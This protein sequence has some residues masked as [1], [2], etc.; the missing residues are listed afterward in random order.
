MRHGRV[1][2]RR[3]R[4]RAHRDA[5]RGRATD[6]CPDPG[7]TAAAR[8]TFTQAGRTRLG[9]C[10][11]RTIR[12]MPGTAPVVVDSAGCGAAMK[13]YG[14]LLGTRRGPGVLRSGSSTSRSG[15]PG[16]PQSRCAPRDQSVVVQDACHLRHVQKAHLAVRSVLRGALRRDRDRRRR[17]VL[18]RGGC[19][20]RAATRSV[21]CRPHA[22]G[23]CHRGRW[24]Y[25]SPSGLGQPR[26]HDA[27]A[28]GG[29][30]QCVTPP[31]SWRLH[32]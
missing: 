4:R 27:P 29:S 2:T 25:A 15:S 11:E 21:D 18:R 5:R 24:R 10:A 13:D 20:Q 16:S 32:W 17:V 31:S 3:P 1:G 23:R 19:V 22:Q 14:R 26:L 28:G 6:G 8:C 7:P 9:V 30:R 12:S